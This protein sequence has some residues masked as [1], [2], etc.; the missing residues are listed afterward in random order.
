MAY[1]RID[2]DSTY[3]STHTSYYTADAEIP[4]FGVDDD[5]E[6][7]PRQENGNVKSF[8]ID[9]EGEQRIAGWGS[10]VTFVRNDVDSASLDIS[11]IPSDMSIVLSSY[12][13]EHGYKS[14]RVNV[15][16]KFSLGRNLVIRYREGLDD[17]KTVHSLNDVPE[18]AS[19]TRLSKPRTNPLYDFKFSAT[20]GPD[21]ITFTVPLLIKPK[22]DA[23]FN[24]GP[25]LSVTR[26]TDEG[27]GHGIHPPT[28][29]S[30]GSETVFIDGKGV[31][32]DGQSRTAHQKTGDRPE[33]HVGKT[34]ATSE[35]VYIEG[36]A[37]ARVSDPVSKKSGSGSCSSKIAQGSETVFS[38]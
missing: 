16:G 34:N 17:V 30:E 38:G 26:K 4:F 13:N 22:Y 37:I 12:I 3:R 25:T 11:E 20:V 36:K 23:P 27:T 7:I 8:N 9:I 32:T 5:G 31:H 1:I 18:G 6:N 15:S 14:F 28:D 10:D 2:S 35:T 24:A 33:R 21:T 19:I 29:N